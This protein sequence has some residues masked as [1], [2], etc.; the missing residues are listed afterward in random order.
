MV[1]V[2]S[3]QYGTAFKHAFSKPNTFR[4]FVYAVTGVHVNPVE[5]HTEYSYSEPVGNVDVI[6]DIFAEDTDKRVVVE[7]QHVKEE[8]FFSRFLHY[9]MLSIVEQVT[10]HEA[11][12]RGALWAK[13][14]YTIVVLASVP[15][16]GSMNF[17]YGTLPMH[18]TDEHGV[19]HTIANHKLI[20]MNARNVNE[21]TPSAVKPWLEF[22]KDTFRGEI[23]EDQY[24]S[25]TFKELI[26]NIQK[27]TMSSS[28]SAA[29]KDE[30]ALAM[31]IE[32][33]RREGHED[34][35]AQGLKDGRKEGRQE[36]LEQGIEQGRRQQQEST[37]KIMMEN[38]IHIAIV[39]EATGL[40]E[41][42]IESLS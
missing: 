12:E 7:I 31:A 27:T 16:D 39:S 2:L 11:Y 32:R 36:G 17:S 21:K 25:P 18:V 23:N 37:A 38:G 22:M 13:T 28:M 34:G 6:Y 30:T 24:A 33:F 14:V 5:I 4:E 29:I 20:F 9:H 35:L 10:S 41:E 19:I 15:R 3:L 8:D 26:D 40:T 42:E 1:E